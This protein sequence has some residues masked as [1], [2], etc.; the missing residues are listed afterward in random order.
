MINA[1]KILLDITFEYIWILLRKILKSIN[2]RVSPLS[3]SGGIR[4]IDKGWVKDRFQNIVEGVMYHAIAIRSR[5][6]QSFFGF[7][8][9]KMMV[10]SGFISFFGQFLM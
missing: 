10:V 7:I 8:N 6:D 5:A 4:I 2:R 9:S 1:W 3:F